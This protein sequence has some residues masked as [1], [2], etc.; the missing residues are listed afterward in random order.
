MVKSMTF[1]SY[2]AF[3][4]WRR[5]NHGKVS[6]MSMSAPT[7]VLGYDVSIAL[8]QLDIV[9]RYMEIPQEFTP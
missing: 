2:A 1:A 6:I 3:E 7:V 9:V 4:V 8:Q 5:K